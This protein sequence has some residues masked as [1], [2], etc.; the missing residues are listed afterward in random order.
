MEKRMKVREAFLCVALGLGL[1]FPSQGA[2][3]EA[4]ECRVAGKC[5]ED[6]AR[7]LDSDD[8]DARDRAYMELYYYRKR[9][10]PIFADLMGRS[11]IRVRARAIVAFYAHR[12]PGVERILRV[13]LAD[14]NH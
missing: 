12:D 4:G 11:S 7:I 9:A 6:F 3:E 5:A 14:A 1:A 2:A 13:A 8:E 10:V